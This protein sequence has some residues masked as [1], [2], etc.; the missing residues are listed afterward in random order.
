LLVTLLVVLAGLT[1]LPRD[2]WWQQSRAIPLFQG[3]AQAIAPHLPEGLRKYIDF[4]GA[5]GVPAPPTA[6]ATT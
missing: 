4:S 5:P 2:P 6:A 3:L 1:P